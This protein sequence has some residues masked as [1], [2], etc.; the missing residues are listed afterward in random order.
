MLKRIRHFLD[1]SG[2]EHED[3]RRLHLTFLVIALIILLVSAPLTLKV[4]G[5]Y[6][7]I[8]FIGL[9]LIV[10]AFVYMN[11]LWPARVIT[12]LV[13][14]VIITWLVYA[15]GIH[16]DALGGYYFI[17]IFVGLMNGRRAMLQF[18]ILSTLA[19]IAI[20]VAETNGWITTRFGPLTES[21]TVA[22]TAFFLLGTTL[23]LNYL[24]VRLNRAAFEAQK[25]RIRTEQSQ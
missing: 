16:D 25:A 18:G 6:F 23:V 4:L 9:L 15:G 21:I 5:S 11:Q 8:G 14:F 7:F 2:N 22:T 19:V 10:L 20:G 17:L 13:G 24:V 1:K 3:Q 12:P